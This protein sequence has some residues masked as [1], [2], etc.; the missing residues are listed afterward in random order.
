MP[1]PVRPSRLCTKNPPPDGLGPPFCTLYGH[2]THR[3]VAVPSMSELASELAAVMEQEQA[4][5]AT[6]ERIGIL[7]GSWRGLMT[8]VRAAEAGGGANGGLGGI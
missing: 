8:G 5:C 1:S 3:G 6:G 4:K 7:E 2:H